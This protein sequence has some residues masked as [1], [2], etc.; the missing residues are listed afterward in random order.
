VRSRARGRRWATRER[1]RPERT[2]SGDPAILSRFVEPGHSIVIEAHVT[3]R[4]T[5]SQSKIEASTNAQVATTIARGYYLKTRSA[6]SLVDK[7]K[8]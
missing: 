5:A 1:L 6:R 2:A 4:V 7:P 3:V 8:P